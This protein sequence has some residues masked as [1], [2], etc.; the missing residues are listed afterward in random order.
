[1]SSDD[2]DITPDAVKASGQRLGDL[3]A[4][5]KA[6]TGTLFTSQAAAAKGNPGFAS[7]PELVT[8]ANTLHT[9]MDALVDD[10]ATNGQKIVTAAQNVQ[11]ADTSST[12]GFNRELA[13]LN[14]LSQAAMPGR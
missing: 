10:M 7:G 6:Q 12:E 8:Y 5:A 14:G 4:K 11:N 2:I 1:M 3:A 13:S 9:Q